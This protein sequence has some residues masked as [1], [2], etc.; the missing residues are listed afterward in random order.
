MRVLRAIAGVLLWLVATVL[1]LT[2]VP[3]GQT[4]FAFAAVLLVS[5]MFLSLAGFAA[6][7]PLRKY[8]V[9]P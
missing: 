8:G 4:L 6:K 2:V 5:S 9:R 7:Q 3:F 1:L